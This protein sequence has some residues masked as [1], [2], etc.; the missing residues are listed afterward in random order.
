M[1]A[2]TNCPYYREEW[3]RR[4]LDPAKLQSPE[5][6]RTWPLIDREVTREHR[7]RMRAEAPQ[8]RLISKATGGSTGVPLQFDLDEGAYAWTWAATFRG[9]SWAG[10]APGVKLLYLWSVPLTGRTRLSA[11]KDKLYHGLYRRRILNLF[12]LSDESVPLFFEQFRRYRPDCIVAYTNPL[13]TFAR[14][15]EERGLRPP[16]PKSIITGAEKLYQHQ[17]EYIEQVFGAPV[18]ETYGSREFMLMGAECDRHLGMHRTTENQFLEVLDDDGRPT[19]DGREGSVVVTDLHNY[20]MPFIRYVNGDRAV[21]GQGTCTCGRGLPLLGE[22]TGRRA[23]I[24]HTPDGRHISGIFFP[25]LMKDFPSVR[26]FQIVQ[27]EPDHIRI[28]A[29]LDPSWSA[30]DQEIL[31][32]EIGKVLGLSVR[33]DFR[34]VKWI[35]LTAQGNRQVV[36]NL[37]GPT[38]ST[39]R[40]VSRN[41]GRA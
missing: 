28:D 13:Y 37:C 8:M 16:S 17:R 21:A 33:W 41:G 32:R 26:A 31:D 7:A 38:T 34:P 30:A 1:H 23:D 4:G 9:Y 11:L 12:D 10:A 3:R 22:I 18:F 35:P 20:G 27:D 36:V 5:D 25:H 24:L 14:A 29:V 2:Y 6:F 15:L 39:H 40:A 19:P